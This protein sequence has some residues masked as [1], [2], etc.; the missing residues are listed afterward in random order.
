MYKNPII[1]SGDDKKAIF[2]PDLKNEYV[3]YCPK[4]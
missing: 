3:M 4:W 2:I 1:T